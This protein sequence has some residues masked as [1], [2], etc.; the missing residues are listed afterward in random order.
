MKEVGKRE[1][2]HYARLW[3][4]NEDNGWLRIMDDEWWIILLMISEGH[5][6]LL[7]ANF[8]IVKWYFGPTIWA[9]FNK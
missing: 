4:M 1:Q 3:M 2:Q 9:N 5:P 8:Y 6:E 7:G